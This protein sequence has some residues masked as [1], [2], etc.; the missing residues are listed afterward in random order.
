MLAR[1]NGTQK[2]LAENPIESPMRLE[3]QLIEEYSS[4]LL[5]EEKFWALK[6]RINVAAIG[7]R[8]TYYF[9]VNTI[10][11]RQRNK[12]RCLKDG[13]GEWIVEEIGRAHV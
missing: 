5:Q 2:V 11:R 10:V 13:M 6:S 4:I 9:H 8:N 12:I 7:D 3:N 1:L